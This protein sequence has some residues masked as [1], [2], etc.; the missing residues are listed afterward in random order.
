MVTVVMIMVTVVMIM[1]V[2]IEMITPVKM[3]TQVSSEY[4]ASC[5]DCLGPSLLT[6][7][8]I[9]KYNSTFI[10]D[11]PKTADIQVRQ[12]AD[13]SFY[14]NSGKQTYPHPTNWAKVQQVSSRV[15]GKW[16]NSE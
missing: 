10:A 13:D 9:K 14:L 8:L 12:N 5:W 15:Y 2:M 4:H 7:L 11:I 3:V 16:H 6:S 1:V